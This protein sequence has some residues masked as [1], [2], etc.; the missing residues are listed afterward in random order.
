MMRYLL[1]IGCWFVLSWSAV[2]QG[3]LN[4]F[5]MRFRLPKVTQAGVPI[6]V[7]SNPFDVLPHRIPGVTNALVANE[8]APFKPFSIF[9][10]GGG[11]R[12]ST[13]FWLLILLFGMLTFS[14]A[15]N[16]KAVGKAWR[17]F[18]NDSALTLAQ[19]EAAGFAGSTPYYL[20]YSSFLFQAGMFFFLMARFFNRESFNNLPFL[21]FCFLLSGGI[22]L[23]KHFL[24]SVIAWLYPLGNAVSRYNFLII[25]FNC[26]LGLFL[27]P[28]NLLLAF[29]GDFEGLLLFWTLGLIVVFYIYRSVRASSI[30]TKFLADDQFHF[31]LYLCIVEI[32][33]ILFLVKLVLNEA[34]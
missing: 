1:L 7:V 18:L 12:Q 23:S 31:L 6:A 17:G 20:M 8:T 33:P 21:L 15:A 16:R 10:R 25:I 19:R 13:L 27:L 24:L 29:G 9:P 14:I 28:F 5:E 30:G 34:N 4:P 22:F 26:I 3:S 32:A 2:A 11:M